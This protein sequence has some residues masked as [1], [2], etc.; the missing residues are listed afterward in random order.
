MINGVTKIVMTKADV[1]DLFPELNVCTAYM[2]NG[3]TN[4]EIPFQLERQKTEPVY[5]SFEGWNQPTSAIKDYKKLPSTMKT[6]VD[7]INKTLGVNIS[8]ISNGPG[9]EQIIEVA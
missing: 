5:K 9:R 6:Y 1:L 7:F 3:K 2:V 8:F 4:R